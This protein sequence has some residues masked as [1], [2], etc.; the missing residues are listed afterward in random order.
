[1]NDHKYDRVSTI[2]LVRI[3]ENGI[4]LQISNCKINNSI[5][6]FR[7]RIRSNG[8]SRINF[9]NSPFFKLF[10]HHFFVNNN[11]PSFLQKH[12]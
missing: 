1:M 9:S 2:N 11:K 7:E 10:K 3:S 4:S 6:N 8:E 12:V 5:K